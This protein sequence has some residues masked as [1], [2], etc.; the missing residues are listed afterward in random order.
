[1]FEHE[2]EAYTDFIAATYPAASLEL[3]NKYG[4]QNADNVFKLFELGKAIDD[5]NGE[6]FTTHFVVAVLRTE[7]WNRGMKLVQ[8][9]LNTKQMNAIC[10]QSFKDREKFIQFFDDQ[11]LLY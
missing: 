5:I 7:S 4:V 1:M 11:K 9:L 10:W 8:H 2:F 6:G 3:N